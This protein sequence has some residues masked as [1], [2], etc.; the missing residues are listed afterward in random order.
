M[1]TQWYTIVGVVGDM[2]NDGLANPAGTELFLSHLQMP[3]QVPP[4]ML[5]AAFIVFRAQGDPALPLAAI[6]REVN[7]IDP[8][9]PIASVRTMDELLTAAQSRPRFL[10]TL[11]TLF[12]IVALVLAAVGVYGVIAYSVAQ[13]TRELGL[14]VALGA[15]PGDVLKLVLKRSLLLT[16]CGVV[17][18]LCGAWGLTR[19]I[20]SLLYGITATDPLTFL[21]VTLLLSVVALSASYLPARAATRADPMVALRA[22]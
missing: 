8:T 17:V 1:A 7:A 19:F 13:R 3:A 2:K 22:E 11:L 12:A 16:A 6:R 14:R 18:G 21:A 15:Q 20:A 10:A 9:L 4:D 5:R